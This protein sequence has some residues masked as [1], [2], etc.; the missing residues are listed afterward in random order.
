MQFNKTNLQAIRRD[1][2]NALADVETKHGI[3]LRLGN[4]S[5]SE[6]SFTAK[7]EGE[8][9]GESGETKAEKDFKLGAHLVGLKPEDFGKTFESNGEKFTITGL[10]LRAS[11]FPIMG[12]C[13]RTGK[14]YK[15]PE[16]SVAAKLAKQTV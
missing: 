4:M 2:D 1:I 8:C 16:K 3:T 10:N 12:K 7:I 11:R 9:I 14:N 5:Y 13:Q 15:F 6:L